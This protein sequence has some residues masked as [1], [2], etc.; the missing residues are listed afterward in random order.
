MSSNSSSG[1]GGDSATLQRGPSISS[2]AVYPRRHEQVYLL[3]SIAL[4]RR[5]RA[6]I[7]IE[8]THTHI[9]TLFGRLDAFTT[10][11]VRGHI[12]YV[13][14]L[15]SIDVRLGVVGGPAAGTHLMPT[16]SHIRHF[17]RGWI[18]DA[19]TTITNSSSSSVSYTH[20]RAHETPEHLVCRLLLEKKKKT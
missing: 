20:L 19:L 15:T 9:Q 11:R 14:Y 10:T 17:I 13:A 4:S 12:D 3:K 16:A 6:S 5:E 2:R 1:G 18:T 7:A 8:A